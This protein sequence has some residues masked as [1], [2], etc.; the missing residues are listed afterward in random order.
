L[1]QTSKKTEANYNQM[2]LT[3]QYSRNNL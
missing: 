3:T 2:K 1:S